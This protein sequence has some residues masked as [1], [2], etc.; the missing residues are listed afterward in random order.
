MRFFL[1]DRIT[2]WEAGS[3]AE[4]VKNVALSEDFFD[5]HFPRRPVMP[6]V[7]ILEGLAQLGGLLLEASLQQQYAKSAKAVLTVLERTKFRTMIKPGDSLLYRT[8]V[9]ALNEAGG[10]IKATARRD[11]QPVT[12]TQMVFAFKAMDDPLLDTKRKHLMDVWRQ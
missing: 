7:L 11:D 2:K 3:Y 5:D 4:G 10:K 9:M 1:I 6:G 8:E 12:S